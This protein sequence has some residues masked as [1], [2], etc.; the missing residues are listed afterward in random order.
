MASNKGF[1]P[2]LVWYDERAH[3][4]AQEEAERKL[5]HLDN[6]SM[7][8]HK[9][10]D[11]SDTKVNMRQL[12][13]DMVGYFKDLILGVFKDVNQ[14]GMSADKLM[15]AKEIPVRELAKIQ[16]DYEKLRIRSQVTFEGNTP[17]I[18]LKRSDFEL[19]TKTERQNKKVIFGNQFI[20]SITDL[21]QSLNVKVFPANITTAT[22]GFIQYD[23][24]NR[25]YVIDRQSVFA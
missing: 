2:L 7:W 4:Q 8:I 1:Q 6:G 15:E 11:L 3:L 12:S 17:L 25:K 23:L 16:S 21:E 10:L 20:K 9:H 22:S 24:R 13:N 19:W 14:L 18:E 5:M